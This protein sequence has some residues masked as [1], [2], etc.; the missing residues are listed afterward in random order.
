[1][2][3]NLKVSIEEKREFDGSRNYLVNSCEKFVESDL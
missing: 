2:G 3:E 1:M